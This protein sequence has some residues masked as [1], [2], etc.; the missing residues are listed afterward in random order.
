MLYRIPLLGA[1][2]ICFQLQATHTLVVVDLS[3]RLLCPGVATHDQ[4]LILAAF[5][6]FHQRVKAQLY[7]KSKDRFSVLFPPQQ[8]VKLPYSAWEQALNLDLSMV[9]PSQ[10]AKTCKAFEAKLPGLLKTI[11]EK[12]HL[13]STPKDFPGVDLWQ[14][15]NDRLGVEMTRGETHYLMVLTDGYFDFESY[16][17]TIAQGNRRTSTS[18]F[19]TLRGPQWRE[20]AQ[21]GHYGLLPLANPLP[22]GNLTIQ[23]FGLQPK[24]NDLRELDLLV[25]CWKD[26]M[27]VNQLPLPETYPLRTVNPA[28]HLK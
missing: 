2:L 13:G 6:Q 23:V 26:W 28:K 16:E 20:K 22:P 25:W 1:L 8:G 18:F 3:D 17:H 7:F 11:Y 9:P 24:T 5:D 27:A 15:F 19:S 14:F 4:S 21:Q 10:R 12:S